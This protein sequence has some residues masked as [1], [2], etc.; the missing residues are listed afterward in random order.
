MDLTGL[1]AGLLTALCLNNT[2]AASHQLTEMA[3]ESLVWSVSWTS[4]PNLLT[5]LHCASV[6]VCLDSL[7]GCGALLWALNLPSQFAVVFCCSVRE[8]S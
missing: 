8:L 7:R 1:C 5:H 3:C 4:K 6:V 2:R